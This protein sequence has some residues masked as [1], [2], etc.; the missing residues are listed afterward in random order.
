MAQLPIFPNW[1][2]AN[3][4][5]TARKKRSAGVAARQGPAGAGQPHGIC[6]HRSG[7][8]RFGVK[9]AI[10]Y[11]HVASA[12]LGTSSTGWWFGT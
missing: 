3:G 9:L 10:Q 6:G 7:H 1:R 12:N 4:A 8:L 2:R 5:S 11:A